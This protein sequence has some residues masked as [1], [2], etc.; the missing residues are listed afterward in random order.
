MGGSFGGMMM[1]VAQNMGC[2]VVEASAAAPE[3]KPR[4][5]KY[6]RQWDKLAEADK[7]LRR[8]QCDYQ[9]ACRSAHIEFRKAVLSDT[10][11]RKLAHTHSA[12]QLIKLAAGEPA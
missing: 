11:L 9:D 3:P 6:P 4:A 12:R 5:R 7:E 1:R 8:L 2:Y 10:G